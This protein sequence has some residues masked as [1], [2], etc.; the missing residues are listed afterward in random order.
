MLYC[1]AEPVR[2]TEHLRGT[3]KSK[4][5][6]N[7]EACAGSCPRPFTAWRT[8]RKPL[9]QA[10]Y[11]RS[12]ACSETHDSSVRH[13]TTSQE[14]PVRP[15]S[16]LPPKGVRQLQSTL[17]ALFW[18]EDTAVPLAGNWPPR[19]CTPWQQMLWWWTVWGTPFGRSC[20]LPG[21]PQRKSA[22]LKRWW[23]QHSRT[24]HPM[25]QSSQQRGL[26]SPACPSLLLM[27]NMCS[28]SRIFGRKFYTAPIQK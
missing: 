26:L 16:L 12:S 1:H 11:H 10:C 25:A 27:G 21:T 7:E 18:P 28:I 17:H 6:I 19:D 5:K 14:T 22:S 24:L 8:V 20:T 3:R 15:A 9:A 4:Q 13:L 23:R 2:L